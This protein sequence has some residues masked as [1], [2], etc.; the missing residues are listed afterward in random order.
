MLAC[1]KN[2]QT[3][4]KLQRRMAVAALYLLPI[5][6]ETSSASAL[7]WSRSYLG[8]FLNQT[9]MNLSAPGYT[10]RTAQSQTPNFISDTLHWYNC[11]LIF[12]LSSRLQSIW[13]P[14]ATTSLSTSR[15]RI[16][17]LTSLRPSARWSRSAPTLTRRGG[18]R[19]ETSRASSGPSLPSRR[20]GRGRGSHPSGGLS[21]SYCPWSRTSRLLHR[22]SHLVGWAPTCHVASL[23]ILRIVP[24]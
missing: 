10:R 19:W 21:S 4:R 3:K 8:S 11:E 14:R 12:L 23:L 13:K 2:S 16:T 17:R 24:L 7:F 1:G 18:R 22:M 9:T 15:S 20:R 5:S 6:P